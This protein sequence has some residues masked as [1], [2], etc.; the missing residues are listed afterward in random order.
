VSEAKKFNQLAEIHLKESSQWMQRV[1]EQ[2]N[3]IVESEK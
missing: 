1:I 3:Q 2:A